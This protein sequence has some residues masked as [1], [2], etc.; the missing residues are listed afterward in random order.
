MR[1]PI[2]WGD[3]FGFVTMAASLVLVWAELAR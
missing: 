3:L 2:P 1:R